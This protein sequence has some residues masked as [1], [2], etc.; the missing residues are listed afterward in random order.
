VS[1]L[2]YELKYYLDELRLQRVPLFATVK[3]ASESV[4]V[5]QVVVYCIYHA[6]RKTTDVTTATAVTSVEFKLYDI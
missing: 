3:L 6:V 1:S 5:C 4:A 2:R